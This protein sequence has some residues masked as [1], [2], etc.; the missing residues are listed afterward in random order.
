LAFA[1]GLISANQNERGV[2][3]MVLTKT[4]ALHDAPDDGGDGTAG[5]AP[6]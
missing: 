1:T 5:T 2:P 6:R 4:S 3:V